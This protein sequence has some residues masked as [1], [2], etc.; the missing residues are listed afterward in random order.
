MGTDPD[1]RPD[2]DQLDALKKAVGKPAEAIVD[3]VT[4]DEELL[5]ITERNIF[6][7]AAG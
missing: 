4:N 2:D 1:E 7:D 5:T 6:K 3:L